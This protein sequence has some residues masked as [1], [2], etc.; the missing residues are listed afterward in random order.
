MLEK[1]AVDRALLHL[2]SLG[3][4][5]IFPSPFEFVFYS[6]KS[7]EISKRV[8]ELDPSKYAPKSCIEILCP[9][10]ELAY[11]I[12]QQ[13]YPADTLLYTSAVIQIAPS[14]EAM[15]LPIEKGPFSYRFIENPEEPRLFSEA[16][17]FHDWLLHVRDV[18]TNSNPFADVRYVIETDISDF[19]SHIYFH[20]L[21]HVLD[22][23][24]APNIVR[25]IIEG[26]IKHSRARQSYGLPVGTSA[27]RLLAEGLL[28]D[29]DQMLA[30]RSSGYTRYVDDFRIVVDHQSA[31]HST[32]CKLAEHLMLT[33]GLALNASKTRTYS[34]DEAVEQVERK[35]SD[36]F[37]DAELA[38]LNKYIRQV[39]DDEEVSVEEIEDVEPEALGQKLVEVLSRDS[40]DYAAVRVILKALRAVE[41]PDPLGLIESTFQLLY[42]VPRDYCILVG[43]FAQRSSDLAPEIAEKM[44]SLLETQPFSEMTLSRVWVTHLFVSQALPITRALLNRLKLSEST[45]EKRQRLL[46]LGVLNDRNY[47]RESKTRFDE[48]SDWEKPALLFGASCLS[49][50]EY[51]TWLNTVKGHITDP[52]GDIYRSWLETNQGELFSKLKVQFAVKS[53]AERI[54]ELFDDLPF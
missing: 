20:R 43:A 15:R 47:F 12:A 40:T 18:C 5:D 34:T 19:Y 28:N 32:L 4:T 11:R 13:L 23:C 44:V 17:G 22:D 37:N 26:I 52:F 16:S 21:E 27:S 46:L 8:C 51:A 45:L 14:I 54:A 7:E 25:K 24:G 42:Y 9:K 6:E 49:K 50:G 48:A 29:T 30:E 53:K 39:Y 36:V 31:V 3:D 2:T 1:T 35:L 33:E 41:Y 38:S 10:R